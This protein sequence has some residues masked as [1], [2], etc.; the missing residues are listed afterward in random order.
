MSPAQ[1]IDPGWRWDA[2]FPLS[3]GIRIGDVVV[4]SGQVAV[5]GDGNIVG[6]NDLKAQTRQ[7][8]RNIETILTSAGASFSNVVKLTTFF[9]VDITNPKLVADYFDVR[10][11]FFG[12]HRPASTGVQVVALAFPDLLLEVEA[13]AYLPLRRNP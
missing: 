10:L 1:F 6:R 7:V 12:D 3:Q 2:D 8:F 11:Q 13:I 9:T 5:D 4:L